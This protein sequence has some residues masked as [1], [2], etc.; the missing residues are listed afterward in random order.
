MTKREQSIDTQLIHSGEIRPGIEG[1]VALKA[2]YIISGDKALL[3][4]R[5]YVSIEI[6]SPAQF[7][8]TF[9]PEGLAEQG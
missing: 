1:A 5:K 2:D 6:L 9:P 8:K 4:V 7:L 3:A